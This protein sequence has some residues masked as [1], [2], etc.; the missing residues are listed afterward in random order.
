[1]KTLLYLAVVAAALYAVQH[2]GPPL[3]GDADARGLAS[4]VTAW[5]W[6]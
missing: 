4:P 2:C 1:M 3:I 5:P 6:E